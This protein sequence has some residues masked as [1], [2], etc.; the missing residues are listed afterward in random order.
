MTEKLKKIFHVFLDIVEIYI[1]IVTFSA[2][3]I[4]F[5][6][7]IVSRYVFRHPLVWPY[8]L[9]QFGYL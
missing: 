2:L 3:F 7:Q 8:E 4:A 6:L 1:P 5:I 9:S